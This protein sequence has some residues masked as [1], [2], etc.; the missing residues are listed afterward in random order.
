MV[1]TCSI[2]N[3]ENIYMGGGGEG[4]DGDGGDGGK[5]YAFINL[6]LAPVLTMVD[7]AISSS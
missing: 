5:K 1:L 3:Y 7:A 4:V 6:A 2:I